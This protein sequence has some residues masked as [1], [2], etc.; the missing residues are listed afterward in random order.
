MSRSIDATAAAEALAGAT[1]TEALTAELRRLGAPVPEGADAAAL[2]GLAL[3]AAPVKSQGDFAA[4]AVNVTIGENLP[5]TAEDLT[6]MLIMAFPG[7]RIG[8]RHGPHYLSLARSGKLRLLRE[9]LP[10]IPHRSRKR[11]RFTLPES[12]EEI[13]SLAED[14]FIDLTDVTTIE[15]ACARV[16]EWINAEPDEGMRLAVAAELSAVPEADLAGLSRR[17][18]VALAK[19]LGVPAGGKS[20][21]IIERIR[22]FHET[23]EDKK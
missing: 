3:K 13:R 21:A 5:L 8:K 10:P 1:T 22:S 16:L 14:G 7:A 4:L 12:W 19:H 9:G 6:S 18:L 2:A 15:D 23:K 17:D 11:S 20:A